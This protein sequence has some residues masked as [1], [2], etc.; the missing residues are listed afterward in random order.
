LAKIQSAC[1]RQLSRIKLPQ[2]APIVGAGIGRFL[3]KQIAHDLN[4]TYLDYSGL[5]SGRADSPNHAHA[6]SDCAAAVA[7]ACLEIELMF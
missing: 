3:A 5:F 4:R 6:I 2:D 7:V 1:E